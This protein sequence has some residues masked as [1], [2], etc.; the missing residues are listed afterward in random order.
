MCVSLNDHIYIIICTIFTYQSQLRKSSGNLQIYQLNILF[1]TF[2]ETFV[3]YLYMRF[4]ALSA[5]V[6]TAT[7]E[8]TVYVIAGI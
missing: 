1:H 5:S 4:I 3:V 7:T 6:L 2:C 8:A